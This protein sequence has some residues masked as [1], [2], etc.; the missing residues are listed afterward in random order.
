MVDV[1][2]VAHLFSVP[3]PQ[4]RMSVGPGL[5]D[6]QGA[7]GVIGTGCSQ[8]TLA[9]TDRFRADRS[10]SPPA[11]NGTTMVIGVAG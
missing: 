2:A 10:P 8:R 1:K 9:D 7:N 5:L 6:E 4:R 3:R 11:L